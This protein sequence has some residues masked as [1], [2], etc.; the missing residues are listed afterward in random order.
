MPE[1]KAF[2]REL[3]IIDNYL[4]DAASYEKGALYGVNACCWLFLLLIQQPEMV[5]CLLVKPD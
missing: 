2:C 4:L 5:K 3:D 1:E